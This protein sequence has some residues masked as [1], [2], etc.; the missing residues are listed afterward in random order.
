MKESMQKVR[1]L[2]KQLF[3]YSYAMR[4]IDFDSETIAPGQQRRTRRS[5]GIFEPPEL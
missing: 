2:E 3:G 5:D 4:V 1:E